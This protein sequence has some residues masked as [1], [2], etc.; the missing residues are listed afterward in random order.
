MYKVR[1]EPFDDN[2]RQLYRF[3]RDAVVFLKNHF[4]PLDEVETRGG[5]LTGIQKMHCFLRYA[6]DPGFQ[7]YSIFILNWNSVMGTLFLCYQ[8]QTGVAED[9]GV[10]QSTVNRAIWY[11]CE[12]ILLR[13]NDWIHFPTTEQEFNEAKRLW[14]RRYNFPHAIGALDCSLFAILKPNVRGD[15][16]VCRKNF[17]ALNVQVTCDG[18]EMIS[19]VDSSWAGSVHDGRVW[20]TSEIQQQ[21]YG[22]A[23]GALLLCDQAYSLTPWTMTPYANPNDDQRAYNRLHKRERVIIERIFC[24][25]K[26]RFPILANTIRVATE[27]VPKLITACMILHNISKFLNEPQFDGEDDVEEDEADDI[28]QEDRNIL[29]RGLAKRDLIATVIRGL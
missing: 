20:R 7:V 21:L 29:Q 26:R 11:V 17:P 5:A 28:N 18:N 23:A 16:Y 27:R 9:V 15:D 13:A 3:T 6:I 12:R 4:L 1:R 22:N 19:S 25:L 24:Q 14:Q 10:H 2:Y 8:F